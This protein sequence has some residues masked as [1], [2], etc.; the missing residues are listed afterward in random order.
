MCGVAGLLDFKKQFGP[1]SLRRIGQ[2][3]ATSLH[4]RGP[5]GQGT[6]IDAGTGVVFGHTRLAIIDLSPAGA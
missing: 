5:D 6:W 1:D 4:H 2:R 3:M